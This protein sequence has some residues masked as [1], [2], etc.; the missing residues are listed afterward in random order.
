MFGANPAPILHRHYHCLQTDRNKIPHNRRHLGV[1][2]G[3]SRMIY[4]PMVRSTQTVHLSCTDTNTVSKRTETRFDKDP[5]YLG[6]PSG[7]SKMTSEPMVCSAQTMHLSCIKI[8]TISKWT[9]TSFHLNLVTLEFHRVRPKP[10][11]SLWYL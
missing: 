1:P 8:S 3:P 5:C 6:V 7:V 2:S 10:F 9:E 4:E 11:L